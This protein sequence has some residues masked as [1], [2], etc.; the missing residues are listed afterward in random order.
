MPPAAKSMACCGSILKA[1]SPVA[2]T[3]G[4]LFISA[5]NRR[6]WRALPSIR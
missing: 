6:P 2:P 1:S 5:A 3:C 4:R